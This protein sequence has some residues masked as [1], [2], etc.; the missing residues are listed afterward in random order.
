MNDLRRP[1]PGPPAIIWALA[2]I[3]VGFE[4]AFQL[5]ERQMLPWPN[6]RIETYI[7]LAFWDLYFEAVLDG[8]EVPFEFWTSFLTYAFL[9]GGLMHL[10]LNGAVFL[11]LGGMLANGMGAVRFLILFA[12]TSVAGALLFGLIAQAEGP[13][14][15]ASG[16]IFGFFGALKSWEWRYIRATGAPA[17]RFWGTIG[18]LVAINVVLAVAFP[19]EGSLAW[20]A[21]LGG[22]IAGFLIAPLLAPNAAGPSPI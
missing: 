21:H 16:A 12:V 14:V 18:G 11:G 13:L 9:H 22:F 10:A 3:F 1:P 19:G 17:N 20:E 4:L 8:R 5:S 15:G 6:L 7:R 2:L